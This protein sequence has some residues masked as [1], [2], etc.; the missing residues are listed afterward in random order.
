[1]ISQMGMVFQ[2]SGGAA[3]PPYRGFLALYSLL[4][5]A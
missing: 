1:M 5:Q 2:N 3:A 4:K